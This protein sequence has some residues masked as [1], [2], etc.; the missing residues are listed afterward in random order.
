MEINGA[1]IAR[2]DSHRMAVMKNAKDKL[3]ALRALM[4]RHGWDADI[5]PSTDPHQSEYLPEFWQRCRFLS[6]FTG[7]AGDIVVTRTLAGPWAGFPYYLPAP[8][9]PLCHAISV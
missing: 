6:G 8:S 3:A 4:A 5:F 9:R 1:L 2:E 7:S